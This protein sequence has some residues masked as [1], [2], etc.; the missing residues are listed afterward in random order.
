MFYNGSPIGGDRMDRGIYEAW[1]DGSSK[2]YNQLSGVG[3]LIKSPTGKIITE[4]STRIP[5]VECAFR[6]EYTAIIHLAKALE[7][8]DV[9]NVFIYGDSKWVIERIQKRTL[10]KLKLHEAD[11]RSLHGEAMASLDS[12]IYY[13][14]QWIPRELNT[15]AHEL[16]HQATRGDPIGVE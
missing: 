4:Y 6:L 5:Y 14:I 11:L 15:K 16:S 12:L 9:K 1:F 2:A 13:R 3:G 10:K 8:V 7:E